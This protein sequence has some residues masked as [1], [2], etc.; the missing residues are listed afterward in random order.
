MKKAVLF[1]IMVISSFAQS[2]NSIISVKG[3]VNFANISGSGTKDISGRTAF[4]A[5]VSFEL[6]LKEKFSLQPEILYSSQGMKQKVAG[7]E[8]DIKYNYLNIPIMVKFYIADS[9]Y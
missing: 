1:V 5:G 6:L 8:V 3:G 9:H 4:H 2:Q 7:E